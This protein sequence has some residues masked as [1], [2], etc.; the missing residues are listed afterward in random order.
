MTC[1]H[2]GRPG[3]AWLISRPLA[4]APRLHTRTQLYEDDDLVV[5]HVLGGLC[6]VDR[7]NEVAKC[8]LNVFQAQV[9]DHCRETSGAGA[10]G[11]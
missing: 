9:G 1:R 3:R 6:E 8:A 2:L 10:V 7:L 11:G 5:L 4:R